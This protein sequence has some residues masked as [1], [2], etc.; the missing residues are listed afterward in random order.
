MIS[1]SKKCPKFFVLADFTNSKFRSKTLIILIFSLIF[2]STYA[3]LLLLDSN[4]SCKKTRVIDNPVCDEYSVIDSN[5]IKNYSQYFL[6]PAIPFLLLGNSLYH[7]YKWICI[8]LP[9]IITGIIYRSIDLQYCGIS[10]CLDSEKQIFIAHNQCEELALQKCQSMDEL[11]SVISI[12]IVITILYYL[13]LIICVK[14]IISEFVELRYSIHKFIVNIAIYLE[15]KEWFGDLSNFPSENKDDIYR[16][17][18]LDYKFETRFLI[19]TFLSTIAL[20]TLYFTIISKLNN[21][22]YNPYH[23][24]NMILPNLWYIYLIFIVLHVSLLFPLL[25]GLISIGLNL[26]IFRHQSVVYISYC[27]RNNIGSNL[28]ES[29]VFTTSTRN[30]SFV[31]KYV[32]SIII[33]YGINVITLILGITFFIIGPILN[34]EYFQIL[35]KFLKIFVLPYICRLLYNLIL[36][37]CFKHLLISKFPRIYLFLEF[38]NILFSEFTGFLSAFKRLSLAI[39]GI[40]FTLYRVDK[41]VLSVLPKKIQKL[42]SIYCSYCV[43]TQVQYYKIDIE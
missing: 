13:T 4:I 39:F 31:G 12:N 23:P 34:A 36:V 33:A 8:G 30:E 7:S 37:R 41:S 29:K 25:V 40:L 5:N 2:L 14:I 6:I 9:L 35:I 42:D 11:K 19:G 43:L 20:L 1:E 17:T 21:M 28:L 26:F 16:N 18:F 38:L 24:I 27:I 22:Y 32:G 3:S 10:D 15:G